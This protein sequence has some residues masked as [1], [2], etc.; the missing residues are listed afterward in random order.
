MNVT[1]RA[2]RALILVALGGLVA[3]AEPEPELIGGVPVEEIVPG[4]G[5]LADGDYVLPPVPPEYLAGVNQRAIVAYEGPEAPGTIVVDP[6][7]KFLFLVEEGGT[8]AAIPLPWAGPG[9]R[10]GRTVLSE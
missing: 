3:C 7:A 8:A 6:H 4:Y 10:C 9:F 5:V 2:R 1:I